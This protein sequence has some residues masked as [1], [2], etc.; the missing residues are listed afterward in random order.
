[1]KRTAILCCAAVLSAC[2]QVP[3]SDLK[4]GD[5]PD[6]EST[7]AGLWM[8]MD[9]MEGQLRSSRQVVDDAALND[10]LEQIAC[11]LAPLYCAGIRIYVV[12][13]PYFNA[14]MAPNGIMEVWTGLL[15]RVENEAQLA[16][17]LGHEMAHYIRRHS[18]KRWVDLQNKAN[19]ASVFSI[20]TSAAGVGY[21]GYM[22][23]LAAF[24]SILSYSRDQERQA[25]ADGAARL[26]EAGY[27][28]REAAR[29]WRALVSE[30][31]ASKN[32]EGWIFFSTHPGTAERIA[33]LEAAAADTALSAEPWVVGR[34]RMHAMLGPYWDDWLGDELSRGAFDESEVLFRRLLE[35]GSKRGLVQFYL[36]ELYR[37]RGADGDADRAITAYRAALAEQDAPTR[38]H[39]SL[40]QVLRQ[41]GRQAEA[42]RA[43]EAYLRAE[44]DAADRAIVEYQIERLR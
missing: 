13:M 3:S 19:A 12:E 31:A 8:H 5:R 30:K 26:V 36:G 4:P 21:A 23:D 27:D 18:L 14:T 38:T 42:R 29:L 16:F 2:A 37:K 1:M 43:Y 7:E 44:P 22:G 25:D 10:Y 17:V 40:G 41:S 28:P 11:Q 9:R 20:L 6:L 24:T 15:L 35:T 34:A 39:R 33:A 32:R